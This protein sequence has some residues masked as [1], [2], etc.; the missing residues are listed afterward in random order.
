MI[1]HIT[2]NLFTSNALSVDDALQTPGGHITCSTNKQH[3]N[4]NNNIHHINYM[5]KIS[6]YIRI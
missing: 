5:C 6:M 1:S 4:N 3:N 2:H